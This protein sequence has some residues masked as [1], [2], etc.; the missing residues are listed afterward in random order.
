MNEKNQRKIKYV[1]RN[2]TM[3]SDNECVYVSQSNGRNEVEFS[4][5]IGRY[6]QHIH[7]I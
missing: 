3:F 2:R 7:Y 4:A 6:N 1:K 5:Y